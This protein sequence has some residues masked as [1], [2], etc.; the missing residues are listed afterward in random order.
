VQK[1]AI[2]LLQLETDL[3]LAI[4]ALI[5]TPSTISEFI[6][7]YQPIVSL[8]TGKITGFEALVRWQHP[9]RGIV[10]PGDFIPVAEETGLIAHLDW[11]VMG[12]ACR[13]V[14]AWQK[15]FSSN[16]PLTIGINLSSRQFDQSD[17]VERIDEIIRDT[18]LE[19]SSLKLEITE[20]CLLEMPRK[21]SR[22]LSS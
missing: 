9:R 14:R 1:D 4:G 12:E 19:S 2:A 22:I 13:Q 7:Y 20:T 21:R 8:S 10:Y 16:H 15:Q 6:V 5:N 17:M 11:W 18:G 3:R